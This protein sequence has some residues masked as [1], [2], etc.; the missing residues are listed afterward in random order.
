MYGGHV[1][2]GFILRL[3]E[4]QRRLHGLSESRRGMH[5]K[6]TVP[7]RKLRWFRLRTERS[8]RILL[9]RWRS[10]LVE[11][12]SASNRLGECV[13]L[14]PWLIEMLQRLGG[15]QREVGILQM[16]TSQQADVGATR[17]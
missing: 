3:Y 5:V 6:L 11:E 2:C 8:R 16:R 4:R 1:R 12:R 7:C 13:L 15:V 10:K 9:R 14:R 17:R